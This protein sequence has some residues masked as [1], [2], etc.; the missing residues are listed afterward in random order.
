MK[1]TPRK[2][3]LFISIFLIGWKGNAQE[4]SPPN[5]LLFQHLTTEK[6]LSQASNN[7][8]FKD[9][10]GF[11]WISSTSGLNRFDGHSVKVYRGISGDTTSINGANIN[12]HF[13][14]DADGNIWFS[15]YDAINCYVR[16]ED[17]FR[18]YTNKD[19]NDQPLSEYFVCGLD[20]QN[21]LWLMHR[22]GFYRFDLITKKFHFV[23][24]LKKKFQRGKIE[25]NEA[26]KIRRAFFYSGNRQYGI[27]IIEFENH[28]KYQSRILLSKKNTSSFTT[29]IV[30]REI[31]P[32]NNHLTWVIEKSTLIALDPANNTFSSYQV[33]DKEN[34]PINFLG[35]DNFSKNHLILT[36]DGNG[37]IFFDKTKK[38]FSKFHTKIEKLDYSIMSNGMNAIYVDS[39][40]GIWSN[41]NGMGVDYSSPNN[42]KFDTY[43]TPND[44]FDIKIFRR[45]FQLSDGRICLVA[46]GAEH[47]II[48]EKNEVVEYI[49]RATHPILKNNNLFYHFEDKQ[50]RIWMLGWKSLAYYDLKTKQ[51]HNVETEFMGTPLTLIF[52]E[53]LR[54]G[55]IAFSSMSG[56][57]FTLKDIS[58]PDKGI[59][60]LSPEDRTDPVTI[61]FQGENGEIYTCENL[62]RIV[63][64]NEQFEVQKT[65]PIIG[66]IK[67]FYEVPNDSILW[68]GTDRGLVRY[69]KETGKFRFFTEDDGLPNAMIY[70][71]VPDDN[72]HLWLST[73]AGLAKINQKN[74]HIE[75]FNIF[76]GITFLEYNTNS[77]LR[78][79]DGTIMFGHSGGVTTFH[80]NQIQPNSYL[81][82]PQITSIKINDE[83]FPNL[84][85]AQTEATNVSEIKALELS[86]KHNT[87]SLEFAA[88]DYADAK[89]NQYRYRLLGE[90][91][92]W[93]EG[94]TR[95][96][97]RYSNLSPKQYEFQLLAANS[98]GDWA[99]EPI[100]LSLLIIPP[101][102]LRTWFL[103]LVLAA[104]AGLTWL[105][106]R[107]YYEYKFGKQIALEKQ[108]V[109]WARKMHED[110]GADYSSL[111]IRI[112][113]LFSKLQ[114][115]NIVAK[116]TDRIQGLSEVVG[117][118]IR[119]ITWSL[120]PKNDNLEKLMTYLQDYAR[121]RFEDTDIDLQFPL[122][123]EIPN[124]K[125]VGEN[126]M[127]VLHIFKEALNNIHKHAQADTINISIQHSPTNCSISIH[128]NG[129][130]FDSSLLS[131]STGN[132]LSNMQDRM[133]EIGGKCEIK[134]NSTGTFVL[135]SFPI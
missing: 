25:L 82:S 20:Q 120:N 36:T 11:V 85:C 130:G 3:I 92:K 109:F 54:N 16:K 107:V 38:Q 93:I 90:D 60:L 94:G 105:A 87:I 70:G 135:L 74:Y 73:N 84:K 104:L 95:N 21:Q 2:I 97:V 66:D 124:K 132:G 1:T 24:D 26:G 80:P 77:Y 49:G 52:G 19:D 71:I 100:T 28:E 23:V 45:I 133:Q 76:D 37:I 12:G 106:F 29:D 30:I 44:T 126:R 31:V 43:F 5:L 64:Y 108:K 110:L 118:Q 111:K 114:Q 61:F 79:K 6:G 103:L 4:T 13:A 112:G 17:N 83:S 88:M 91:Q 51:V 113:M 127:T 128:D 75:T 40:G 62:N 59:Q 121:Q 86:Y 122:P 33:F 18:N 134:T 117:K 14:E 22:N 69:N 34:K 32:E 41:K 89:N 119:S 129:I 35:I 101:V 47:F 102:Y 56:G 58:N 68:I 81:A 115:D 15:S 57:I 78:K 10:K 65:I 131:D 9:S 46:S 50:K 27:Q 63:V 42:V 96:F 99:K 48:N 39:E 53:S 72:G 123:K 7:F 8:I 116:E 67:C 125:M 98:D 55:T